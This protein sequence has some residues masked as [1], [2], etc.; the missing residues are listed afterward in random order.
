MIKNK[1]ERNLIS[2]HNSSRISFPFVFI[3]AANNI[4]FWFI[5]Y[6]MSN[7]LGD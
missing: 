1:L 2:V 7:R 4:I 3:G 6:I 5:F